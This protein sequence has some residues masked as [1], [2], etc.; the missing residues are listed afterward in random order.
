MFRNKFAPPPPPE[1]QPTFVIVVAPAPQLDALD[2]GLATQ[3]MGIDMVELHEPAL[4]AAMSAVT[5]ESAPADI[6]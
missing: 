3:G 4:V 5:D 2:R 1:V 6:A